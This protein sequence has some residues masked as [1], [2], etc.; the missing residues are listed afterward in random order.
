[1]MGKLITI[2]GIN[3]IGKTTHS[4]R[5]VERLRSEGYEAEYVKFPIYDLEPAGPFINNILRNC[6][7]QPISEDELQLW[8]VLNRYQFEPEIERMVAEGKIVVAED[9]TGTGIAWGHAKGLE[10]EWMEEV[11]KFLLKEDFAIMMEGDR[12][13]DA[14]EDGH[15]HEEDHDLVEKCM[16]VHDELADKYGWKRV[17]VHEDY[18]DTADLVWNAVDDFLQGR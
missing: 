10:L 3:N 1:M 2:Y 16:R 17:R 4:K 6:E 18:D 5:L 7:D 9:Y 14:K 15:I 12:K 13:L 8:F 11:N